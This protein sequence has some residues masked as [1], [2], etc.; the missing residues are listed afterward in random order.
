MFQL[1]YINLFI[2]IQSHNIMFLVEFNFAT[3][4]TFQ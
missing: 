2:V 4:D 1:Y 3:E